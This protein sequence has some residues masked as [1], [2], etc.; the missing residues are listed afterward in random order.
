MYQTVVEGLFADPIHGG[1]RDKA[2]WKLLGFPGAL[3][4]YYQNVEKYRGKKYPAAPVSIQD[5]S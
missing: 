2:G 4:V 3:A 1:N 5:M